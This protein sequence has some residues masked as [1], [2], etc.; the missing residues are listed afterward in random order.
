[1]ISN[2]T[3]PVKATKDNGKKTAEHT[4][5]CRRRIHLIYRSLTLMC[6][7]I[8]LSIVRCRHANKQGSYL[9]SP[10]LH[11]KGKGLV[12]KGHDHGH[13]C[14]VLSLQLQQMEYL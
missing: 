3:N 2:K 5:I 4:G 6:G 10:T 7:I 12:V 8:L 14:H 9:K 13:C 11:C 1:M